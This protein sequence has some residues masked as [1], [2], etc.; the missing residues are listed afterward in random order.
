MNF[1]HNFFFKPWHIFSFKENSM[2]A[3]N[4]LIWYKIITGYFFQFSLTFDSHSDVAFGDNEPNRNPIGFAYRFQIDFRWSGLP[5]CFHITWC[6]FIKFIEIITL[7]KLAS[8]K[9]QFKAVTWRI[10]SL[11]DFWTIDRVFF[12][13]SFQVG[14]QSLISMILVDGKCVIHFG[15]YWSWG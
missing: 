14:L 13:R 2:P 6:T 4:L 11:I 3:V 9:T 1:P 8:I 10:V 5:I 7:R 12:L 15:D